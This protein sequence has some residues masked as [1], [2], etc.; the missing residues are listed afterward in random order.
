ML[1]FAKCVLYKLPT[2][3]PRSK[4]DGNMGT[5][6]LEGVFLGFNRSSNTYIIA[7]E[8][9]VE[10][11]RSLYR[12]PIENRWMAERIL[13]LKSTPW[14]LRE[15]AEP[16]L[17]TRETA[18]RTEPN[19]PRR[20]GP[21]PRA[22]RITHADL[23]EHGFSEDCP[24]CRH[25]E[26]FGKS[27]E[28]HA[29]TDECRR[30]FLD[31]FMSTPKG[32]ARLIAYEERVDRAISDRTTT[33][34]ETTAANDDLQPRPNGLDN[35]APPSIVPGGDDSGTAASSHIPSIDSNKFLK[36]KPLRSMSRQFSSPAPS[37][38]QRPTASPSQEE[39]LQPETSS[40][41]RGYD[42]PGPNEGD[43]DMDFHFLG[44]L[45]PEEDDDVSL[46]LLEQLGT[47]SSATKESRGFAREKRRTFNRIVSEIYSP[48]RVTAEI[49]RSGFKH[50]R[51][52]LALDLTV[53]DPDD[54]QPWDFS[55][56]DKR[57][58][59]RQLIRASRPILLIGSP[60]CTAFST[61]QRLNDARSTNVEAR[62]QAYAKACQHI[63]FVASL[64][65]EQLD[66]SQYF[67]HEHPQFASS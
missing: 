67:L 7:T 66:G 46:M 4:P 20:E 10:S 1:G 57:E 48:P 18:T 21:M 51:A 24:Q 31:R 23:Q 29:H 47:V 15:R 8:D 59:A 32:R 41:H 37:P 9:G 27:K 52:G 33:Q 5:R 12:K 2:K 49:Q 54:G 40:S 65:R 28:G 17:E 55:R 44:H 38:L 62:Q 13:Q 36:D 19:A 56:R 50:L 3:G 53:S 22:F 64:Y 58:K 16:Q 26:V 35:G 43:I 30:R 39:I 14:L 61:W 60:M 42:P 63:K 45:G 34:H 6:W 25:N 11:C